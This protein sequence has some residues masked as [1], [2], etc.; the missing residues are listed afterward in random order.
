MRQ[1]LDVL[2]ALLGI[3]V[4]GASLYLA[5]LTLLSRRRAAPAARATLAHRV[6]FD[7][8]VPAHNEEVGI[9]DTVKS[10]S[11]VDYPAQ[12]R[13]IL[14]V[15]AWSNPDPLQRGTTLTFL[16]LDTH[17]VADDHR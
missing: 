14:V 2:L 8:I 11:D 9:A 13:R 16:A 12:L 3:P 10:L 15:A 7:L 1:I 5:V 17:G 4:L 6:R